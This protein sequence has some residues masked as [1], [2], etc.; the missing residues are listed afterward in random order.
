MIKSFVGQYVSNEEKHKGYM[1]AC[2]TMANEY[3]HSN[4][5]NQKEN[6]VNFLENKKTQN[7]NV[8][9]NEEE[10]ILKY[11]GKTIKKVQNRNCWCIRYYQDNQ[12]KAVY[13]KTQKDVIKK[14][15]ALKNN[16][17]ESTNSNLTL[18]QWFNKYM[19]LYKSKQVKDTTIRSTNFDF[20]HLK[21][22][23]DKKISVLNAFEIQTTLNSI[24]GSSTRLRVYT[25][26]N[27]LFEKA[28]AHKLVERNIIKLVDRPKYKAKEK[29]ALTKDEEQK[30]ISA[31]KKNRF[32]NFYLLCLYQGLR[33][34]E[35]RALKVNDVNFEQKTLRIDESINAHTTR[36]TTKNEQSNRTIPIFDKSI[37]I[38][39]K[40]IVGKQPEDYLFEIGINTVDRVLSQLV[41]ESN[42]RHIT[43]HSLRHTF[44]TRCQELN[45]P[46]YVVQSWV[47]HEKGSIITTKIY[48]HLNDEAN[49]KF[50]DIINNI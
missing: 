15:K 30:F 50:V 10:N 37:D 4:D 43:T 42:I 35:C 6:I 38:I 45:I 21:E 13:G 25:L 27:A 48:T 7:Q 2:S 8:Y 31:C 12:Q 9:L 5:S 28:F 34:G 23:F 22:L 49:S 39:K 47:G 41:N 33:K 40:Q 1:Q 18:K 46:L 24:S 17:I 11:D 29:I 44:I 26:L 16:T 14:Y 3:Y 19:D 36:T 20:N 32:G